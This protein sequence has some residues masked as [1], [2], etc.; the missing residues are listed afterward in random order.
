VIFVICWTL[1]THGK[2]SASG[3]EPHYL[4]TCQSLW[5]DGDLDLRNNYANDDGRRF[6]AGGLEIGLHAQ[7]NRTGQLFPVHDIG[8]PLVLAPVYAAAVAI[9]DVSSEAILARFRMTRGLFAYS[10]I[11]ICIIGLVAVAAAVT[12]RALRAQ[13]LPPAL[14]SLVVLTAWLSP[15]ALSNSFLVFPEPFALLATACSIRVA[16]DTRAPE[17]RAIFLLAAGLGVLPWF[18]RKF[19][20]YAAAL[21]VAILWQRRHDVRAFSI[22]DRIIVLALYVAPQIGLGIWTWHHWGNFGGPLTTMELPPFSWHA[23]RVGSLGLFVDRENGLLVWAP[24]YTLIPAAWVIAGRR[25]AVW[26]LPATLLMLMSAAHEHWWGGFSPAA[27]FLLPLIP[28]FA[29]VGAQAL[30]TRRYRYACL[31]LLIP[32]IFISANGWQ[33]P[34]SLWPQGDGHNVVVGD[35]MRWVGGSE[36]LLPSLRT[37]LEALGRATLAVAGLA[38]VN[39]IAAIGWF[40]NNEPTNR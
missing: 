22:R 23:F 39:V 31:A 30:T 25:Y 20:V 14:V 36:M 1:T 33:H 13:G 9:S 19:A 26:L 40:R 7:E 29:C 6:G 21:L 10:L 12:H 3:D 34:R 32:Q 17:P 15:P 28:I 11:S 37:S 8:V 16:F 35:L 18:H 38:V 4:M 2:Y 27:R 24:V 5:A